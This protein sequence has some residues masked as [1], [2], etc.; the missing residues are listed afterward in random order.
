MTGNIAAFQICWRTEFP[1]SCRERVIPPV[2]NE[3]QNPIRAHSD[4]APLW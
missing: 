3:W 1:A 4:S 2:E